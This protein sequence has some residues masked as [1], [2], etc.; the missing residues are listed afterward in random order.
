MIGLDPLSGVEE[1]TGDEGADAGL[2]GVWRRFDDEA[3]IRRA[4][5]EKSSDTLEK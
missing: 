4:T 1:E 2:G 3:V 5:L